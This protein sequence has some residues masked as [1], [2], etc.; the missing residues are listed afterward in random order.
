M[1]END[2]ESPPI[3]LDG[4]DGGGKGEFADCG[5]SFRIDDL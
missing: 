4:E 5:L 3:E 1:L 2:D